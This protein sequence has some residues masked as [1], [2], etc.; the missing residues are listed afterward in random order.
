MVMSMRKFLRLFLFFLLTL[1][2]LLCFPR[3]A[4]AVQKAS[5]SKV[6]DYFAIPAMFKA[7]KQYNS[8]LAS[9]SADESVFEV[10]NVLGLNEMR[11]FLIERQLDQNSVT[12]A[13]VDSGA[14]E[15]DSL[16]AKLLPGYNFVDHS[17]DTS[18]DTHPNSHG[19]FLCSLIAQ[20]TK[21]L[22]VGIMPIKVADGKFAS[23]DSIADGICFAVAHGANII[24]LSMGG[25]TSNCNRIEE[26]LDYA[27]QN[28]VMV[29]A[30]AGNERMQLSERYCPAHHP[31]VITV[32]TVDDT[33]SFAFSFSN[34]GESIDFTAPG[35]NFSGFSA[36][37]NVIS[38]SGTSVSAVLISTAAAMLKMAYP[39]CNL[40]QLFQMMKKSCVDLG[41]NGFDSFY[42]NGLP[43]LSFFETDSTVYVNGIETKEKGYSIICGESATLSANIIPANATNQTVL[44]QSSSPEIVCINDFG[45]IQGLAV[46][47]ATITAKTE[48]GLYE[49]R[50]LVRVLAT[51]SVSIS[52]STKELKYGERLLITVH[53]NDSV[54]PTRIKWC[55][56]DDKLIIQSSDEQQECVVM[57]KKNGL[58]K[59]AVSVIDEE[60]NEY[61]DSVRIKSKVNWVLIVIGTIKRWFHLDRVI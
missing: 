28:G 50:I 35:V 23:L 3:S 25:I 57:S 60:G 11:S 51:P 49:T 32:S 38:L 15:I 24:N 26:A 14:A 34:Y 54:W 18:S 13:V 1:S 12:V 22:P 56:S 4:Y 58:S 5:R 9:K 10:P 31:E 27:A 8:A 16:N 21:N 36:D 42:G 45:E 33:N 43:D 47:D 53:Y 61:K 7:K 41:S 19:T 2:V 30:A 55:I 52:C 37:G 44:W 6:L 29:V 46:G 40:K 59:V 48:D 39:Q 17:L 20:Y